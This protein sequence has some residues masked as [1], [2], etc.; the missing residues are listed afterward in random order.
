MGEL[1][2]RA[3]DW[4]GRRRTIDFMLWGQA[5]GEGVGVLRRWREKESGAELAWAGSQTGGARAQARASLRPGAW[6]TEVTR[7]REPVVTAGVGGVPCARVRRS[8]LGLWG[9]WGPPLGARKRPGGS[10]SA[11]AL[12][13][14]REDSPASRAVCVLT[15]A[16]CET[17]YAG[18]AHAS[19]EGPAQ[20]PQRQ[21]KVQPSS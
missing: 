16:S 3:G 12:E 11:A 4:L 15:V 8:G 20:V 7:S 10:L 13:T 18:V 5:W 2:G 19:R 14:G 21:D 1:S 9:S 6:G 17:Q